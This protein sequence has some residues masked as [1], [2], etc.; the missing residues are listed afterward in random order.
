MAE[1]TDIEAQVLHEL[2]GTD[3]LHALHGKV[4]AQRLGHRDTRKIRL[5]IIA[6]L[7]KKCTILGDATH[8]YYIAES[9]EQCT[10]MLKRLRKTG[11]ML[12]LHYYYLR[13][14]RDAKFSKQLAMKI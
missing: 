3:E 13:L 2:T 11:K 7:K 14:A 12:F 4:L 9:P 1:L 6:L 8:G 5:A 10:A